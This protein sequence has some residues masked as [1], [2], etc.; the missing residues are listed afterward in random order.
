M[1]SASSSTLDVLNISPSSEGN[2][3]QVLWS[4]ARAPSTKGAQIVPT[5]SLCHHAR[6][7]CKEPKRVFYHWV[8]EQQKVGAPLP[9][10]QSTHHLAGDTAT[11]TCRDSLPWFRSPRWI[12]LQPSSEHPFT[13][14]FLIEGGIYRLFL[15][16]AVLYALRTSPCHL[17]FSSHHPIPSPCY[18]HCLWKWCLTQY[19]PSVSF[20]SVN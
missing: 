15:F 7:A 17:C 16:L 8:T 12:A 1:S 2:G 5:T 19:L 14:S 9:S 13:S 6:L 4:Q 11:L 18:Q 10:S 20:S 3:C